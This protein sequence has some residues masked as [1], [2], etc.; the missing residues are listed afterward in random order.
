MFKDN[1]SKTISS[2]DSLVLAPAIDEEVRNNNFDERKHW[3]VTDVII[4]PDGKKEVREYFNTVVDDCSRLIASLMK[5]QAGQ[6][7]ITYWA[8]GSGAGT[9][10]N[11]NPPAPS[12]GDTKLFNETFRKA[13][14]PSDI[15]FLDANDNVTELITNKLQIKVL[16]TEEEANGELREFGLFG[17]NATSK[18]DSGIM[19]NRKT[20]GLI[21]KTS[22]MQLERTIRIVF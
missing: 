21:Y 15:V 18:K 9:W 12:V 11:A 19:I 16:F 5:G 4:Y 14:Q 1:F 8:V 2:S 13:I 7:G 17:G 6:K 3:K 10:N 20:H 22:G